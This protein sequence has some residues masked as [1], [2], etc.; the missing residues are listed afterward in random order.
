[1]N[2]LVI[3]DSIDNAAKNLSDKPT[4][5]I[6]QTI[7]DL[8]QLTLGGRIALAAEKQ[9]LKYAHDLEEYRRTLESKVSTIPEDKQIIAPIQIAAQA[10]DDSKYCVETEE[11]RNLFANLIARSMHADYSGK[12]HPSFSK[13]AQQLS[14]LDAKMLELLNEWE[15]YKG[16]GVVDCKKDE[17]NG[18]FIILAEG[19]PVIW[20]QNYNAFDAA[21]SLVVLQQLGLVKIPDG[22]H[23]KNDILYI[24]VYYFEVIDGYT[25]CHDHGHN[26]RNNS[27]CDYVFHFLASCSF[28]RFCEFYHKKIDVASS[29]V[30]LSVSTILCI[31]PTVKD[32]PSSFI[33]R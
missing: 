26:G 17:Q 13:I 27:T 7:A 1:M 18:G 28:S 19:I 23:F 25:F 21:R 8:W 15:I 33:F 32:M 30:K 6:G 4:S 10:L 11:L 20:P 24:A 31:C 29:R 5:A 2:N 3:P 9:K 16:I 22:S 12:L 14:P